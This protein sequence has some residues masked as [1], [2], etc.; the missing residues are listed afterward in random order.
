MVVDGKIRRME[1]VHGVIGFDM[2][3]FYATLLELY[4]KVLTLVIYFIIHIIDAYNII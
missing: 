3:Y 1:S 2:Q 4:C